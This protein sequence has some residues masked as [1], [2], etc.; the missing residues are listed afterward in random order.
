VLTHIVHGI[1]YPFNTRDEMTKQ[2]PSLKKKY[3]SYEK[4]SNAKF[5]DFF[6][7]KVIQASIKYEAN[8]F[9]STY[10]ENK[11]NNTFSIKPL[12]KAVQLS[13]ANSFLIE[14]F[15]LD[16]NLDILE[17]G[18]FFR[19][20]IQMGRYDASYGVLLLGDGKNNFSPVS[21]HNSGFS[22]K[23]EIRGIIPI[24]INDRTHYMIVRNNDAV[25]FFIKHE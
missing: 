25:E 16:G 21:A 1:E 23:G 10:I 11:G 22:V 19:S 14:D 4:F 6:S 7:S 2:M 12:P 24:K 20:N 15:N 5:E 13:T 17:G 9:E 3:L 8:E 18:N